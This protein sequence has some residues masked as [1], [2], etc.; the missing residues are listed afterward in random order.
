MTCLFNDAIG[1]CDC[2]LER[3]ISHGS[4]TI[5]LGTPYLQDP[6]LDPRKSALHDTQDCKIRAALIN[7]HEV[8]NVDYIRILIEND[9]SYYIEKVTQYKLQIMENLRNGN[10][11]TDYEPIEVLELIHSHVPIDMNDL[12]SITTMWG[13]DG[14]SRKDFVFEFLVKVFGLNTVLDQINVDNIITSCSTAFLSED[15]CIEYVHDIDFLT[16]IYAHKLHSLHRRSFEVLIL[17]ALRV[18]QYSNMVDL[19]NIMTDTHLHYLR[20][21]LESKFNE[22]DIHTYHIDC[23]VQQIVE[24][25]FKYQLMS[26]E[27]FEFVLENN[28]PGQCCSEEGGMSYWYGIL[29]LPYI[30][31]IYSPASD[32]E[33]WS[34]LY[35]L[36]E[37]CDCDEASIKKFEC[38]L[39]LASIAVW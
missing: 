25:D 9:R 27:N 33:F 17:Y 28:N 22:E 4:A 39:E 34:F 32:D 2:F 8:C 15:S 30:I 10:F 5:F 36:L 6:I 18:S 11:S 19:F 38:S 16:A 13:E 35:H 37:D 14:R 1:L 7:A 23:L 12:Q 31:R 29:L 26:R 24:Y 21:I 20:E 3:A